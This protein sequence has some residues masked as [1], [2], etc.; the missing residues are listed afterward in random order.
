[1]SYNNPQPHIPGKYA[2]EYPDSLIDPNPTNIEQGFW[3]PRMSIRPFVPDDANDDI[4]VIDDQGGYGNRGTGGFWQLVGQVCT[5]WFYIGGNVSYAAGI[6]GSPPVIYLPFRTMATPA[7]YYY[8]IVSDPLVTY[9]AW[10]TLARPV[11]LNAQDGSDGTPG[12]LFNHAV[13]VTIDDD[14]GP[15]N[16]TLL[17]LWGATGGNFEI[18]GSGHYWVPAGTTSKDLLEP[19]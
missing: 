8:P 6:N 3:M 11:Y 2:S 7:D 15:A 17:S 4:I 5:Y 10:D 13:L 12:D 19:A 14:G 16:A 18:Y 9:N 1:M